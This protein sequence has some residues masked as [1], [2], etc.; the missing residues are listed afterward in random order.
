MDV[1]VTVS[2]GLSASKGHHEAKTASLS[3]DRE[4]VAIGVVS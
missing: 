4:V 2:F 1:E 3:S